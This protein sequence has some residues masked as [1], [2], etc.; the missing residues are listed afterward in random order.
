MTQRRQVARVPDCLREHATFFFPKTSWEPPTVLR[1]A[2]NRQPSSCS[3][4]LYSFSLPALYTFCP[5]ANLNHCFS[6]TEPCFLLS[7]DLETSFSSASENVSLHPSPHSQPHVLH[8]T[9]HAHAQC[10]DSS[11]HSYQ[12]CTP[13][14]PRVPG[15]PD[16]LV[17]GIYQPEY[18]HDSHTTL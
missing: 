16:F 9:I 12:G 8:L 10:P 15:V 3:P 11:A 13:A 18:F 7:S 17:G 4:C 1:E 14:A 2:Q 5:A 6:L